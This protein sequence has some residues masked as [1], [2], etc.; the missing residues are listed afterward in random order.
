M[1]LSW[2]TPAHFWTP[3]PDFPPLK[4]AV[5]ISSRPPCCVAQELHPRVDLSMF[6]FLRYNETRNP[7]LGLLLHVSAL[8]LL[9]VLLEE[10]GDPGIVLF[11]LPEP[12]VLE[13]EHLCPP[14]LFSPGMSCLI[15]FTLDNSKTGY[16]KGHEMVRLVQC[17]L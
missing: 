5:E 2:L 17:L 16:M 7:T 4:D 8:H 11:L 15:S 14:P 6:W 10:Q 12:F 3:V 9:L 13:E 1:L